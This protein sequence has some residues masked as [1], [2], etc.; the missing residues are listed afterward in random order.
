MR[1]V[2]PRVLMRGMRGARSIGRGKTAHRAARMGMA[3]EAYAA[4]E[5]LDEARKRKYRKRHLRKGEVR[6]REPI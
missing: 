4:G 5:K 3:E 6:W 1:F 2:V